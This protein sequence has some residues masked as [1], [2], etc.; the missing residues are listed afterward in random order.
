MKGF[1]VIAVILASISTQGC[2]SLYTNE[3][4]YDKEI[5][6]YKKLK[7]KKAF[8]SVISDLSLIHI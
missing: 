6:K 2:S 8:A 3:S 7:A 5:A 1:Y 4:Q